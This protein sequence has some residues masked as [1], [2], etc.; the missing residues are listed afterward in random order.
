VVKDTS[1]NHQ[2][3]RVLVKH[4]IWSIITS[5]CIIVYLVLKALAMLAYGLTQ[6]RNAGWDALMEL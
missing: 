2:E 3:A 1:N 4:E 5:E 6:L